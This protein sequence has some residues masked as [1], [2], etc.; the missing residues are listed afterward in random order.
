MTRF[1]YLSL[2]FFDISD[3]H[4]ENYCLTFSMPNA[5][6]MRP[7]VDGTETWVAMKYSEA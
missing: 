7:A 5:N 6:L 2:I 3:H 4:H 1:V